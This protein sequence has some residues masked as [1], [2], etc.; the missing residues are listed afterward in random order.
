MINP[1]F[2]EVVSIAGGG[3]SYA[4]GFS[5][6]DAATEIEVLVGTLPGDEAVQTYGVAWSVS[7]DSV[8]FAGG[9]VPDAG[10]RVV[11]RRIT[12]PSQPSV[13]GDTGIFR[14]GLIERAID[15][16]VRLV[17][18]A[19]AKLGRALVSATIG[20]P[21]AAGGKRITGLAD[22]AG[23]SDAVTLGQL[24]AAAAAFV[25]GRL[26]DF[27]IFASRTSAQLAT[28]D[29]AQRVVL[30]QSYAGAG[31]GG[32][33][34]YRRTASEPAHEGKFR[35]VDRY[36]P[37]GSTSAGNG[38]WWEIDEAEIAPEMFDAV[39]DG[40]ADDII[41]FRKALAVGRAI[42]LRARDYAVSDTV[43]VRHGMKGK[44][45]S[46]SRLL[47]SSAGAFADGKGI[48][49]V[50][51]LA[52]ES[53]AVCEAPVL[54]GFS[55][56]GKGVRPSTRSANPAVMSFNG[57]GIVELEQAHS[58]VKRDVVVQF[59]LRG[60]DHA[61]HYGHS[62]GDGVGS[63]NNWY[64]VYFSR[65]TG[66]YSYRDSD[67]TGNL[68]ASIGCSGENEGA[69][70][71]G[72][73]GGLGLYRVHCGFAPYALYQEDG[74]GT[75]GLVGL[76][77]VDCRFEAI[78]NRAIRG[79]D[80]G[81][82]PSGGIKNNSEWTITLPG[83][84]WVN[85]GDAAAVANYVIEG[86]GNHPIQDYAITLDLFQ[87]GQ[88]GGGLHVAGNGFKAGSSGYHTRINDLLAHVAD[89]NGPA[90]Y[91]VVNQGFDRLFSGLAQI[92]AQAPVVVTNHDYDAGTAAEIA[93]FA[94]PP[95]RDG[96]YWG[97]IEG[98]LCF[99]NASGDERHMYFSAKTTS[100]AALQTGGPLY[101]IPEGTSTHFIKL[102]VALGERVTGVHQVKLVMTDTVALAVEVSPSGLNCPMFFSLGQSSFDA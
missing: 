42:T 47:A 46:R 21:Y 25:V 88:V 36:L 73:V 97:Y 77:L 37:D 18:N 82:V 61:N 72:G 81:P 50:G 83:H 32:H 102:R 40:V 44:G 55:V 33:A 98:A 20:A 10:D 15:R 5:F 59:C 66:D 89:A 101:V 22:G 60:I 38:G 70:A 71:P 85:L 2:P 54:E 92:Y 63:K 52:A 51:W 95:S 27:P 67:L 76:T 14:P 11:R 34:F 62:Y 29:A 93:T 48:V 19:N 31:V 56:I 45:S 57:S 91:K 96:T 35:S 53:A 13:F 75:T 26:V 74:D 87:P 64:G 100:D 12:P 94:V 43:N 6:D 1:E 68:F 41:P 78:G 17:Q 24:V 58:V 99:N 9:Y 16:V 8:V 4:V 65:N 80:T 23:D 86:D 49:S 3:A 69:F 7:G 84:T 79:G 30:L 39:A 90:G 28:I